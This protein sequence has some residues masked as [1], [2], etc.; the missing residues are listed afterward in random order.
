MKKYRIATQARQDLNEISDDIG[1]RNFPAAERVL[2]AWR[3]TFSVL[4]AQPGIRMGRDDLNEG[5][6][7]FP[8]KRPAN[9][10]VIC[11]YRIDDG[12]EISTILYGMQDWEKMFVRG[13]R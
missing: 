10:Y 7:V 12:I 8:G 2:K 4:A 1:E 13:E 3:E 5:L 11:Y 6:H 9:Q